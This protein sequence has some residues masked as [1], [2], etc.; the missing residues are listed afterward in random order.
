MKYAVLTDAAPGGERERHWNDPWHF[1]L[2]RVAN[3]CRAYGRLP[4][5]GPFTNIADP[6][7]LRAAAERAAALGFEGKWAIHPSQ[8]DIANE[9][10]SP[11]A[12]QLVWA[13]E[14]LAAITAAGG[15]GR[16]AVRSKDGNMIDMA[17]VKMAHSLLERGERVAK[18]STST[19]A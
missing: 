15:Q 13:R 18:Q 4:I 16:G 5:D 2:A 7:G 10:F 17:H 8:I 19:R 1:A 3:A 12:E 6:Q 11:S 9:V 14:V